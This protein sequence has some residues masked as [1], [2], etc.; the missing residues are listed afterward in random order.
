MLLTRTL[1]HLQTE[2][3]MEPLL[4]YIMYFSRGS[5]TIMAMFSR[6]KTKTLRKIPND[7]FVFFE[8]F[9]SKTSFVQNHVKPQKKHVTRTVTV[10]YLYIIRFPNSF[11]A[12]L[13]SAWESSGGDANEPLLFLC[14]ISWKFMWSVRKHGRS[15]GRADDWCERHFYVIVTSL[16]RRMVQVTSG[17][18]IVGLELLRRADPYNS[19]FL[20]DLEYT[21]YLL[22]RVP[23]FDCR[24]SD[25]PGDS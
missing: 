3:Q 25:C 4:K 21:Y 15:A 13:L 22:Y 1:S 24:R 18:L 2:L 5:I 17:R 10:S 14:L 12:I 6:F 9:A 20:L 8:S 23:S 19:C 7:V 16:V 11:G